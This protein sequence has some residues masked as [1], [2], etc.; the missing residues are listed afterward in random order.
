MRNGWRLDGWPPP[1]MSL[2]AQEAS[3][4]APRQCAACRVGPWGGSR[5]SSWPAV[6]EGLGSKRPC[7]PRSRGGGL[8]RSSGSRLAGGEWPVSVLGRASLPGQGLPGL[9]HLLPPPWAWE[10][11]KQ[12]LSCSRGPHSP[13]FTVVGP[14]F[15][16]A[17]SVRGSGQGTPSAG[18]ISPD[19][20]LARPSTVLPG[21]APRPRGPG[22]G[23]LPTG[24]PTWSCEGLP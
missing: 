12:G 20:L 17:W 5:T 24:G 11:G 7:Q 16:H 14:D 22:L 10:P 2:C 3:R 1:A 6:P 15:T 4:A 18:G 8:T 21:A 9:C 13:A 23:L 19:P